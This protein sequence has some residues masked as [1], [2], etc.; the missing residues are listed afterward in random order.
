[1]TPTKRNGIRAPALWIRKTGYRTTQDLLQS[2]FALQ[3]FILLQSRGERRESRVV[4]GVSVD[5][6]Q[7]PLRQGNHLL[8]REEAVARATHRLGTSPLLQ[9][10][11]DP[12]SL[13]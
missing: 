11:Q 12:S 8:W 7:L 1:M 13:A 5:F 10:V 4:D 3:D 6:D 9:F 2:G